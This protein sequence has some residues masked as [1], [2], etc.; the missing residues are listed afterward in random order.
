L[1]YVLP[2]V[3]GNDPVGG[4]RGDG[5]RTDSRHRG[6]CRNGCLDSSDLQLLSLHRGWLLLA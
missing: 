5:C 6:E 1:R 3:D 2:L 4:L